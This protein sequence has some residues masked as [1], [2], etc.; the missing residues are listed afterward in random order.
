MYC[1]Y[2]KTQHS[3]THSQLLNHSLTQSL[4]HS[5]TLNHS[6]TQSLTIT[7]NHSITH[8]VY[9][10]NLH[11]SVTPQQLRTHMSTAGPVARATIL[12]G[13][14]GDSLGCAVVQYRHA[15]HAQH[16][17]THLYNTV[18]NGRLVYVREDREAHSN[19]TPLTTDTTTHT[20]R[21]SSVVREKGTCVVV[22]NIDR[23]PYAHTHAPQSQKEL[24]RHIHSL[25]SAVGR[26]R[27]VLCD[28][29]LV[30]KGRGKVVVEYASRAE[31][32]R[33]VAELH[34]R[35]VGNKKIIVQPYGN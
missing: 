27:K 23:S 3:L 14:L 12:R 16:A 9:Y 28:A 15:A 11:T 25:M 32:V 17:L 19:T 10:R 5:D 22:G 18:L 1:S 8:C 21:R 31:A 29:P 20:K 30:G 26:V 4:N 13:S 6:I 33:A 34:G 35:E 7:H 2:T 24:E